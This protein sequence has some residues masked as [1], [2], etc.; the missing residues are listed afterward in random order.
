MLGILEFVV[1]PVVV[2][3]ITA[4]IIGLVK[5]LPKLWRRLRAPKAAAT[6]S[7]PPPSRSS[8]MPFPI[9]RP[10]YTRTTYAEYIRSRM[11]R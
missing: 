11:R 3:L 7:P 10:D 5:Q 4:G 9:R 8:S 2:L 6:V 1:Y